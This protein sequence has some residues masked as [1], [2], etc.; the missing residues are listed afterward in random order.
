VFTVSEDFNYEFSIGAEKWY[1]TNK[2]AMIDI[3]KPMEASEFKR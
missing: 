3:V 2:Q 1:F